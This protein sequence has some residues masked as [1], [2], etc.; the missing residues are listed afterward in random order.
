MPTPII[1]GTIKVTKL[2]GTKP[3][4]VSGDTDPWCA[5]IFAFQRRKCLLIT[6]AATCWS[7]LALD[8]RKNDLLPFDAFFAKQLRRQLLH[9]WPMHADVIEN[10]LATLLPAV[11]STTSNDKRTLGVMNRYAYQLS[12]VLARDEQPLNEATARNLVWNENHGLVSARTEGHGPARTKYFVP[13][14][15]M[16]AL[17]GFPYDAKDYSDRLSMARW[18]R[19]RSFIW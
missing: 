15:K 6:H 4:P 12:Y 13:A 7:I 9:E 8:V 16:C 2:M 3:I 17:L 14:E 10:H 1:H 5:N 19:E 11:L 18:G